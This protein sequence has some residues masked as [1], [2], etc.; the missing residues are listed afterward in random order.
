MSIEGLK[1]LRSLPHRRNLTGGVV[2]DEFAAVLCP[3][4]FVREHFLVYAPQKG[5]AGRFVLDFA[6]VSAKVN[7]ELDGPYH[8]KSATPEKD[9]HRD[10]ILRKLGW[11]IIRIRHN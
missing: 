2:G 9:R 1:S 6:H 8:W 10:E 5:G 7:I 3:A 11:K 4:G